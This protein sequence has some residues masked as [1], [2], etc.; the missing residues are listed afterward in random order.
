MD[1]PFESQ[2][3]STPFYKWNPLKIG[4]IKCNIDGALFKESGLVGMSC[5]I[6]NHMGAFVAAR[7][8]ST[9]GPLD[10]LSMEALCCRVALGWLK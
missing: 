2:M 1:T 3:L 7:V 4:F 5:V 6:Q 9:R 8:E 10:A